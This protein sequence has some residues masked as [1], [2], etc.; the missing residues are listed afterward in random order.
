M[1]P[2]SSFFCSPRSV[3]EQKLE[4]LTA[5]I[6]SVGLELEA[7]AAAVPS[8]Q[9]AALGILR[10]MVASA[11]VLVAAGMLPQ[12]QAVQR[13]YVEAKKALD[14]LAAQLGLAAAP[15]PGG[16]AGGGGGGGGRGP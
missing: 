7:Q 10:Q 8:L 1:P 6:S 11:N 15:M 9:Q 3:L 2:V 16:M 4:E 13:N 5:S 12:L 14:S